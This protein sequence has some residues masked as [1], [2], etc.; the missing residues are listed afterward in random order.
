MPEDAVQAETVETTET[1]I[2]ETKV[3]E[4]PETVETPKQD[5]PKEA[6]KEEKPTETEETK[7]ESKETVKDAEPEKEP[8]TDESAKDIESLKGKVKSEQKK[9]ET[10]KSQ[11][12]DLEAVVS[13]ILDAKLKD[14]PKEYHGLIPESG[15]AGKLDWINKAE[16]SGLFKK[17]EPKNVEIGKPLKLGEKHTKAQSN[18]DAQQKLSNYFSNLY[19]KN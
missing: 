19:S 3:D 4:T 15:L 13:S 8:E 14:I 2:I 5:E 1:E 10:L 18:L 9:V 12:K 11:V 17:S 7:E 6:D 16:A